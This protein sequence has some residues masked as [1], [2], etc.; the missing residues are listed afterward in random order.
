MTTPIVAAISLA[1]C[2]LAFGWAREHR[3]RLALQ[4]LLA[5]IFR[6]DKQID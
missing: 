4:T 1:A 5:R 3:L 6:K 2:L